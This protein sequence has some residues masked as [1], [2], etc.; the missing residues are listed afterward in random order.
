MISLT[1]VEKKYNDEVSIGP[2]NLDIKEGGINSI[3]GPNGAGKS[4]LLMMIGRLLPKD[5]GKISIGGLDIDDT[6]PNK[7]AKTVSI[8]K[9][10]NNFISKLTVKQ[11][12]SFGRFPYSQ[13]R[14]TE[15]DIK[16][17]DKYIDFFDLRGLEDRYL[18]E[19]SGGQRQR[20]YVAMVLAQETKYVLLDEP[21]NN[22][23]VARSI[24]MMKHLRK[25]CDALNKTFV[26]V[27]HDIN[28]A[29][30]YSDRI[31]AMKNGKLVCEGSVDEV[32]D[33][34]RL[35]KIFDTS[36]NILNGPYGKIA[37]YN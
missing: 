26:L 16:I 33:G 10:E 14:L 36:I 17:I 5:C 30:Q 27:I 31:F 1:N 4:T 20:A 22:L 29:A 3:I 35:S 11:L 6:D 2:V 18:D 37:V 25:A 24:S 19:L 7:M 28:I 23:D 21:L 9:Q 34:K 13:G 32:M 15:E 12:I 8:L